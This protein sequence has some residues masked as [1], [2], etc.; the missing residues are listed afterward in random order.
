MPASFCRLAGLVAC[1]LPLVTL[2][3]E[4][5]SLQFDWPNGL[6]AQVEQTK[7]RQRG[8]AAP[9]STTTRYAFDVSRLDS[10]ELLVAPRRTSIEHSNH[11]DPHA[12]PQAQQFEAVARAVLPSYVV[13]PQGEFVRLHDLPAAQAEARRLLALW[14]TPGPDGGK[15]AEQVSQEHFLTGL[16]RDSWQSLVGYW[17]GGRL[18]LG[19]EYQDSSHE[20]TPLLP[21]ETVKMSV[22]FQVKREVP[23]E[24]QGLPR[25][26]VEI[27]VHSTPDRDDISRIIQAFLARTMPAT[28]GEMQMSMDMT[29]TMRLVTEPD[30]LI[31]HHYE[32]AKDMRVGVGPKGR[33]PVHRA[34]ER[35]ETRLRFTYP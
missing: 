28:L 32:I 26:C 10:G 27:E 17:R 25:R 21:G 34:E 33:E 11:H 5:V 22:R 30:S 2:A 35:Q 4:P 19:A 18:D 15:L 23:C 1:A 9:A 7:L 6:F 31:P 13:S 20:P 12:V 16:T 24:R 3:A 8:D 29:Q 14:A